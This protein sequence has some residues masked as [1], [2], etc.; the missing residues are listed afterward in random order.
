MTRPASPEPG[1]GLHVGGAGADI[2]TFLQSCRLDKY[3]V[4]AARAHRGLAKSFI[5][6]RARTVCP[7]LLDAVGVLVEAQSGLLELGVSDTTDLV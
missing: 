3:R 7:T 5:C 2:T 1:V 6:L 4:R